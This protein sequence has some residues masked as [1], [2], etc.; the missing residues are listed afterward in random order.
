M[1]NNFETGLLNLEESI[2]SLRKDASTNEKITALINLLECE[3][4]D[5]LS[6]RDVIKE[7]I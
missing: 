5:C 2:K 3:N 6:K 4:I 7:E 1:E